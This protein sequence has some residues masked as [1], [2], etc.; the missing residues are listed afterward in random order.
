MS[1]AA[2]TPI[3]EAL[4]KLLAGMVRSAQTESIPLRRGVGRILAQD[5]V[6]RINVPPWN[7]SAMDG[8]A[9]RAGDVVDGEGTALKVSQR[10][11]AGKTGNPVGIGE[12]ARIFTGA[13][14]PPGADAVVMQENSVET[15][16]AGTKSVRFTEPVAAGDNIR[17][18]GDDIVKGSALLKAGRE[19]RP[20]DLALL[21]SV[22]MDTISVVRPLRVALLTTGDELRPPGEPLADGEIYNSNFYGIA[23]LLDTLGIEVLD[24][25][26]VPD[27][28]GDTQTMLM[29]AASEADCVITTGGV[30]VGEEDHVK[31]VVEANGSLD[32]WKL[33]I[34]PG[35]PLACGSLAG[36]PFFGLPGNPVSAFVTFVLV[37]R[38]CLLA[39][40]GCE[41]L[42]PRSYLLAAAADFPPSGLR[43]EYPRV[44]LDPVPSSDDSQQAHG[45]LPITNQSS[46]VNSSLS[47]A[48]GLA[49]IPPYTT[50]RKGDT[51]QFI[52]FSE[53]SI[54]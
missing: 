2:L 1:P 41:D 21:A 6:A 26:I 10:I 34:K 14:I 40:L 51:L 44:I 42:E 35:K 19:L 52:P 3:A 25:G 47:A 22:G 18:A 43:Q 39:M 54:R 23:G 13:P 7:N 17:Q 8:Y 45:I 37:V 28:A 24:H 27:N 5:C 29:A 48:D 20:Q 46:G 15:D 31:A 9:V 53:F 16:T 36:V 33:A 49:I 30:S 4:P 38:P 50:I 32:L 11:P 12:A